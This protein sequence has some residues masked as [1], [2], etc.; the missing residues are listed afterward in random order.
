MEP[1]QFKHLTESLE[2][3]TLAKTPKLENRGESDLFLRYLT[4]MTFDQDSMTGRY[5]ES[6]VLE[7]IGINKISD[8]EGLAQTL[9]LRDYLKQG[10]ILLHQAVFDREYFNPIKGKHSNLGYAGVY[11]AI[12]QIANE[13][14]NL[15]YSDKHPDKNTDPLE[16]LEM[17]KESLPK[18]KTTSNFLLGG[19]EVEVPYIYDIR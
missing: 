19:G 7:A 1:I 17:L 2:Q 13:F 4:L 11:E 14:R 9:M 3:E 5:S 10:T 8:H 15:L 12:A 6:K 16:W 18:K